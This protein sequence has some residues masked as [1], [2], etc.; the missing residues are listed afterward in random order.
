[1]TFNVAEAVPEVVDRNA[2]EH[3][4]EECRDTTENGKYHDDPNSPD[5]PQPRRQTDQEETNG[6]LEW[7]NCRHI[8]QLTDPPDL[9]CHQPRWRSKAS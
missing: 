2:C 1:V 3:E 4:I 8:N 9:P 5:V 6:Q 7:C